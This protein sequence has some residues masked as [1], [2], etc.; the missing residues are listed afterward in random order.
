MAFAPLIATINEIV[1]PS[2]VTYRVMLNKIDPRVPIELSDAEALLDGA[3]LLRFKAA[4][5]DYKIHRM[6]P[7]EGK[8]VTQYADGDSRIAAKA[9]EGLPAGSAGAHIPLGQHRHTSSRR[10]VTMARPQ[11]SSLLQPR[12]NEEDTA[13]AGE[14]VAA[15][16]L[17]SAPVPITAASQAAV[18]HVEPRSQEPPKTNPRPRSSAARPVRKSVPPYLRFE[19]KEARLRT[20]QLTDL[21]LR[22]RQLNKK[23]NTDAD[24]ITDNTLIRIAVDLLLSRADELAGGDEATLRNSLGI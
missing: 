15:P 16:G 3:G 2:K 18:Q 14:T 9:R 13:K 8:V 10:S 4:I 1:L 21:T 17:A 20:D 5:R 6:A 22:A 23:K 19:R 12:G 24:R 11:L 7:V